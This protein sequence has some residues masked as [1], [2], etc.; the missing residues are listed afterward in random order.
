MGKKQLVEQSKIDLQ[1]SA[2]GFFAMQFLSTAC[3]HI[4]NSISG[5]E[6][7]KS[8]STYR[9]EAYIGI[10]ICIIYINTRLRQG[11]ALQKRAAVPTTGVHNLRARSPWNIVLQCAERVQAPTTEISGPEIL[12]L[13]WFLSHDTKISGSLAL[14]PTQEAE[15]ALAPGGDITG[16][17]HKVT[18]RVYVLI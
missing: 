8:S 3:F 9:C 18:Q 2:P 14:G 10:L 11:L 17:S 4:Q 15:A 12:Y 13:H 6:T 7:W 16:T 1:W 5:Q